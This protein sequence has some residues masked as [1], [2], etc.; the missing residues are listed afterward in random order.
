METISVAKLA[1]SVS[2]HIRIMRYEEWNG[3]CDWCHTS[4]LFSENTLLQCELWNPIGKLK[5]ERE[6][7]AAKLSVFEFA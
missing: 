2:N 3:E 6:H 4:T 5:D 7:T 1:E